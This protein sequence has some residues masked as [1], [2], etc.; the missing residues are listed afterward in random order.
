MISELRMTQIVAMTRLGMPQSV[1]GNCT[2]EPCALGAIGGTNLFWAEVGA[3]P[4]DTGAKTEEGHR[5]TVASCKAII[6]ECDWE[7]QDG[8]SRF[9]RKAG[10]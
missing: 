1:T 7:V 3:N 5:E 2:H 4:R 10:R 8:P 6:A 9:Y